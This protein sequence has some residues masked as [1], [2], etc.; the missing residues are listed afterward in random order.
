MFT[1]AKITLSTLILFGLTSAAMAYEAPENK[2]GDRYPSL[3]QRYTPVAPSH[4]MV[5][6]TA[7]VTGSSQSSEDVE[8]KIGDRYP[9]L[10]QTYAVTPSR[11]TGVRVSALS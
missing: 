7:P 4:T 10:E 5:T 3:E 11:N 9:F 2:I 1:K 8:E 6:R